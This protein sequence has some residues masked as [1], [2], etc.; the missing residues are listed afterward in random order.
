MRFDPAEKGPV[1]TWIRHLRLFCD[2]TDISKGV[3]YFDTDAGVVR[4]LVKG[5]TG[6][7]LLERKAAGDRGFIVGELKVSPASLRVKVAES[8]RPRLREALARTLGVR[9]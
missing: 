8:T 3:T 9:S 1:R 7:P 2:G 4:Y 6:R 5:P